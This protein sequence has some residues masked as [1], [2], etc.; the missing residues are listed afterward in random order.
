MSSSASRNQLALYQKAG[1]RAGPV[2][3]RKHINSIHLP[4][5]LAASFGFP[6]HN[7]RDVPLESVTVACPLF[8]RDLLG[9]GNHKIAVGSGVK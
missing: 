4:K 8:R 5:R 2:I 7:F 9:S 3:Q 1:Q 6:E